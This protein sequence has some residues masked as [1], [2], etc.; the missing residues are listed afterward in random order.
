[1]TW[2]RSR[3]RRCVET[4]AQLR[5]LRPRCPLVELERLW[6][7]SL[8]SIMDWKEEGGEEEEASSNFSPIFL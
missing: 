8:S 6:D 7:S 1:M 4:A 2:R 3:G 5:L